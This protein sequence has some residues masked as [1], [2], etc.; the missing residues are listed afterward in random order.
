MSNAFVQN[1]NFHFNVYRRLD[2]KHTLSCLYGG[3]IL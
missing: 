1:I 3:I 2:I